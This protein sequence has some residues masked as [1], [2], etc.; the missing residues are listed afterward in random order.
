V[1]TASSRRTL[2]YA[3]AFLVAITIVSWFLGRATDAPFHI[4]KVI[5]LG[6]LLVAA[7][8]VRLVLLYFMEVREAPRWLK[9]TCDGWL[10][11]LF[12]ALI[13]FYWAVI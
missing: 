8:K 7:V 1:T 3:W 6:V 4:D 2:I 9:W 13:G 10:A 12:L 11:I 5:T